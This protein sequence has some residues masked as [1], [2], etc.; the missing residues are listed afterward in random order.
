MRWTHHQISHTTNHYFCPPPPPPPLILRQMT[1]WD[2]YVLLTCL[3]CLRNGLEFLELESTQLSGDDLSPGSWSPAFLPYEK[4]S[5]MKLLNLTHMRLIFSFSNVSLDPEHKLHSHLAIFL[6][7][8]YRPG[9][10]TTLGLL[11]ISVL[12]VAVIATRIWFFNNN[13]IA[14]VCVSKCGSCTYFI[15][16][17]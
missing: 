2:W 17:H 16:C 8:D 11:V 6:K 14:F 13:I 10:V 5:A 9:A 7:Y 15:I 1:L 3:E 12:A 4:V